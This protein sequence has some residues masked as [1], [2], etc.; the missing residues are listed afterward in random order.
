MVVGTAGVSGQKR[1]VRGSAVNVQ[2][3]MF[4][5]PSW[6]SICRI[7]P[8]VDY[9]GPSECQHS[10]AVEQRFCKPPVVG[11]IPTVGSTL[12]EAGQDL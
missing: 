10:S 1:K 3:V 4:A 9:R 8:G 11:S 6:K 2:S 12:K 5:F 7:P